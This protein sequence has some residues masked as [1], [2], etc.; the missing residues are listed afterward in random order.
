MLH[1]EHLAIVVGRNRRVYARIYKGIP[2]LEK[3]IRRMS[4]HYLASER[5]KSAS[6]GFAP[7]G[8]TLERPNDTTWVFRVSYREIM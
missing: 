8:M 1:E 5:E 4:E 3:N 7:D 6:E 2:S